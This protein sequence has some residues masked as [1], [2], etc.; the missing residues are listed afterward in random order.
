M[1]RSGRR[2][3]GGSKLTIPAPLVGYRIWEITVDATATD[4]SHN[5]HSLAVCHVRCVLFDSL[6][7]DIAAWLLIG[8]MERPVT[9][10][11]VV[12]FRGNDDFYLTKSETLPEDQVFSSLVLNL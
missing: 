1:D 2:R 3:G 6:F 11:I 12:A 8:E 9:V 7:P 5:A 10:S 4:S